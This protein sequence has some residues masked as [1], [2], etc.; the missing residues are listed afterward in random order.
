MVLM[1][2]SAVN[3]LVNLQHYHFLE[4]L[5]NHHSL[6][7]QFIIDHNIFYLFQVENWLP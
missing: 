3:I 1:I 6:L 4:T 2:D 7:I 5:T